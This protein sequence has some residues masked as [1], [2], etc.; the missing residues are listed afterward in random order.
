ML[1]IQP[2]NGGIRVAGFYG[3]SLEATHTPLLLTFLGLEPLPYD[4]TQLQRGL[5][6]V[7]LARQP[8][9]SDKSAL[10]TFLAK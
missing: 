9:L 8:L 1:C 3:V 7:V 10:L 6:S 5:E 4:C 2:A